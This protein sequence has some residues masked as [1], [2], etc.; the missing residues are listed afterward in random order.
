MDITKY[1]AD[2]N[3]KLQGKEQ[4]VNKMFEYI[5]ALILKLN[6]LKEQLAQK[7]A[8]HFPCL[9]T[10][11]VATVDHAKYS[12]LLNNLI[13]KFETRF[14]DFRRNSVD[15][16]VFGNPFEVDYSIVPHAFQMELIDIQNNTD[17]KTAFGQ[18][19]FLCQICF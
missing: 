9:S 10:R 5:S 12:A 4:F 6:L 14:E 16:K 8:V 11:P 13:E 1:L 2:L 7:K 3:L 17:L 18:N 19:D 15:M